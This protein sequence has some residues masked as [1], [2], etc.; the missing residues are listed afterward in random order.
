MPIV[1]RRLLTKFD[2]V[3]AEGGFSCRDDCGRFFRP[4][5]VLLP[6][7]FRAGSFA[8]RAKRRRPANEP[9][10]AHD[11]FAA[12]GWGAWPFRVASVFPWPFAP[13]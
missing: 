9:R 7:A 2:G 5:A 8:G 1:P 11:S 12:C 4:Q 6:G 13:R 3:T 10:D